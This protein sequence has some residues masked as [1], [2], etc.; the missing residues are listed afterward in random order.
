MCS[1][2]FSEYDKKTT[3]KP[4]NTKQKAD[5]SESECK[6]SLVGVKTKRKNKPRTDSSESEFTPTSV[7]EGG[8]K[9]RKTPCADIIVIEN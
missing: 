3:L 1:E 9:K 4:R 2:K 5:S 7:G 6:Q 8:T